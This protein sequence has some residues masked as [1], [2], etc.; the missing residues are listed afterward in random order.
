MTPR[1]VNDLQQYANLFF[2]DYQH[3][4]LSRAQQQ[5]GP[6]QRLCL[7]Y[8]TGAGKTFTAL[9]CLALWGQ[10]SAT[11]VAPPSTHPA[12]KEA[13]ARFGIQVV[14]ISHAKYRMKDTKL[15]RHIALIVDEIHL[16]GGHTGKGWTKLDRMA[17]GLQAPLIVASATPNYN[18]AERVYCIQHVL[19]PLSCRGGYLAFLYANCVTQANRFSM[20]PDVTGF[21]H[22]DSAAEYLA[23]LP[24]VEYLEDD[25]EYEIED[26][27]VPEIRP[28]EMTTYGYNAQRHRM[29]ASGMEERHTVIQQSLI[30]DAGM[31]RDHPYKVVMGFVSNA[32][33][34][35]LVFANHS[36]VADALAERL[37]QEKVHFGLVTGK[38]TSK[39]KDQAIAAFNAGKLPV[40]V[41]TASLATGT[42]GMD[43]VCDTLIILDDTDDDSLR[44]QL[45]GRIMPRGIGDNDTSNKRVVRLV[46][47]P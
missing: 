47:T 22:Y 15:S 13:A 2:T 45:I 26:W 20:T 11:V 28:H 24:Y 41:G 37:L 39:T 33:H 9:A 36:T 5:E 6:A 18:D 44:R 10:E 23:A 30:N 31:L 16:L 38:T 46:L 19:D 17:G 40:L 12:W 8:K 42:D 27:A 25:L 43:K 4:T 7:Y 21:L 3:E 1:N 34:P 14:T 29:I 32:K 35:V